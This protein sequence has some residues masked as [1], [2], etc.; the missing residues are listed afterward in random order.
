[1]TDMTVTV[2]VRRLQRE[3]S[4]VLREVET[5]E[6]PVVVTRDGEEIAKIVPLSPA[7][8]KWRQWVRELGGEPDDPTWRR[9][10]DAS[11]MAAA[12]G[13]S[14]SDHLDELRESER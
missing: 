5:G 2:T 1:M 13:R 4:A 10:P 12:P 9:P 8:R 14:L 6:H 7:E 11:P 3:T